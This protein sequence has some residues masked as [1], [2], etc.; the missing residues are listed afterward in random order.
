MLRTERPTPVGGPFRRSPLAILVIWTVLWTIGSSPEAAA[1]DYYFPEVR[2]SVSVEPDG[3]FVIDEQRTFAFEGSFSA[4]WYTL[5]LSI[6]RKGYRYNVALEDFEVSDEKGQ[7]LAHEASTSGGVYRA[8]W[9]FQATDEQRTFRIHYRIRNGISSYSDVS[10]FYWQ[11]IGSGW[12]RPTRSAV[13]TI[14]LPA[15]V[16][17]REDILVYGHGPLSG[18]AE[19]VDL[20]SARFTASNL[21]AGQYLEIRM[22]WPA[23]MV[24]GVPSSR[25]TR[26]SIRR[27]EAGFV[28]ET[29]DRVRHA[30]E[31]A[32]QKKK[33]LLVGASIWAV[34]LVFGSLIWFLTYHHFWNRIGRDYRFPDIP[35]YFREP[36]STLQPALVDVLLHE[37][38]SATPRA[39]TATLFDLARRG[40][41]EFEDWSVEKRGILGN[42][43]KLETTVH[44]KKNYARDPRL[45]SYEKDLLD[46]LFKRIHDRSQE[47]EGKLSL[48]ALK[49]Y[50]KKK[51]QKFQSWYL[52][53]VKS[54]DREATR[55][56]FIEPQSLKARNVFLAVSLPLGV[57]TLNP[58]L[59]LLAAV[60]SPKLKR[61]ALSWAKEN[62]LWKGLDRFLDDFS[63]F[64]ELPPEAYK[65]W[66]QYLVFAIV[67][68]KAK[69]ILKMLPVILKDERSAAPLWYS[70]LGR[71]AFAGLDSVSSMVKS[72]TAM[73]TS[74]ENASTSSS[75]Y[76]SGAGGGFSGGGGGGGGGSGG[77]AR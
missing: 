43:E 11:V 47:P 35:Q 14:A 16:K 30:Q 2:I 52:T 7:R 56:Q 20:R 9:N 75:H 1:K 4:A 68:G 61:R 5:P 50:M 23:G 63:R 51:P 76:S 74:N 42:R 49:N 65:L 37:G 29:I 62:E 31:R 19:V 58:L 55:L 54:I 17:S 12:D 8:E 67:F 69:K 10:E 64:E 66:E 77:G 18:W 70:S 34:W 21:P 36:P 39:F 25:H 71:P 27:E 44:L 57:L 33:L 48:D 59:F 73:A 40:W 22:A 32:A 15:E 38:A 60:F 46:F 41:L 13:V 6:E 45:L 3:S 28:Q 53:W 72:I 26:E 24:E